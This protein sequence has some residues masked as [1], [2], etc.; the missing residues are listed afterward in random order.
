MLTYLTDRW[1][2]FDEWCLLR[3]IDSDALTGRRLVILAVTHLTEG[4]DKERTASFLAD[5]E[6]IGNNILDP[7]PTEEAPIPDVAPPPGWK[8]DSDNWAGIQAALSGMGSMKKAVSR[9]R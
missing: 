7:Q 4:L 1:D 3:G 2:V 5:L 9:G 8:S 6:R